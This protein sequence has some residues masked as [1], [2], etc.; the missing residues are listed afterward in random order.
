MAELIIGV[1]EDILRHISVQNLESGGVR[2][3]AARGGGRCAG[4]RIGSGEII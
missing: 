4:G 2:G 3:V 1:V